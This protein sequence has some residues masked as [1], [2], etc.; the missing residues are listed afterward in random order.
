MARIVFK[1]LRSA[2]GAKAQPGE[3]FFDTATKALAFK[4]TDGINYYTTYNVATTTADGLMSAADKTFIDNIRT[5]GF[6]GGEY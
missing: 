2:N 6:D 3:I 5:N 1:P 4:D